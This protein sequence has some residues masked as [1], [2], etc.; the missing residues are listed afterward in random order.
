MMAGNAMQK[1]DLT[2]EEIGDPGDAVELFGT[3]KGVLVCRCAM[4]STRTA[5]VVYSRTRNDPP[6]HSIRPHVPSPHRRPGRALRPWFCVPDGCYALVTR[7]GKDE[8]YDEGKPIWPA[9]F[10]FGAPWLKVEFLI[11]KQS[12]VFNMPVK[13]CKTSD[14]V[15]VQINLAL[16]FRIM[17][18]SEKG[19]DPQMARHFVY[20]VTP[21]GLE[22]QLMDACEEATRSVARSLQHLEVYGLRTDRSG[23]GAKVI[24]G[25]GDADAPPEELDPDTDQGLRQV[26]GPS[27]DQAAAKAMAKGGDVA[28]NMRRTLNDQFK[29][30]G[31]EITDVIITDVCLPDAIVTQMANK[32]MVVAQNAAQ[33]MNQEYEMLTLK[34]SEEVETLK[35][36]KKEEREKEKQA[37][38]QVV[39]E[40][41]VQL[42]K[43]KAET[44]VMLNGVKQ[45]SKVRVQNITADGNLEVTKLNQEKDAKL[46]QLKS[47]AV[48]EAEK[49]K[50]ETDLYEAS[51]T[52]E[53]NFV[54]AQN[55]GKAT[56]AMA[57]AEG[58][59]A[60]YVDA[61][62][63]FETKQKQMDV[64]TALSRNKD[65]VVSGE[66][67][68]E[69]NTLML[70]DAIMDDQA[71]T[72]TKSQ[73][74]AEMLVMQRG[75]KVMLNLD[76]KSG[77]F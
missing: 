20:R 28:E 19:E 42:D 59:A 22:Q 10:H 35:Q 25:A 24:K 48:A 57:K 30:Q 14:N 21:R 43:M 2:T 9:G 53:A 64:W 66:T 71:H 16:V 3:H 76:T 45:D 4:P 44:K 68:E 73:V 15:T 46:T 72:G 11:T 39:N 1:T 75:S 34:Q 38:D 63:Q 61:R 32:T 65:L 37:G 74:L 7:F 17:C 60:P 52:S 77:S 55:E 13:G 29:A 40:V 41:Q 54:K 56:E 18:D 33:K 36:R 27:D 26:A 51:K 5:P 69:L 31:V 62:K 12:V 23:K 50:A 8:N 47:E 70:C 67:N 6:A 49:L 58:V